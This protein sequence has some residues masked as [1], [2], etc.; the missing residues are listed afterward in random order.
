M[1]RAP[2]RQLPPVVRLAS[3]GDAADVLACVTAAFGPYV[4]RMGKAPG[5]MLLDYPRLIA[6]GHVWVAARNAKIEGVI[7][8]F[9]TP[10][11]FYVDTV[12][13]S[14]AARGT[15]VGRALLEFA[16]HE[17]GRRGFASIYLCTN[18]KMTE[19]QDFYP[20]IGY[21]E[22]DRRNDAG[23]DRVFYRKILVVGPGRISTTTP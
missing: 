22:Y 6:E 12:A 18:A 14:P 23:Y 4:E 9:E 3:G 5:P 21:V 10:D 15:G 7:V 2:S 13:S 11:G 16:E 20:R 1:P 8:Q 17:A 19:N